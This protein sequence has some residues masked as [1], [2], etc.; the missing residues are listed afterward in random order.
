MLDKTF[1]EFVEMQ[2]YVEIIIAV[3]ITFGKRPF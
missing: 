3:A 1:L 2:D